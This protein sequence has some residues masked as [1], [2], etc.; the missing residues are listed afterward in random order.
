[1][2]TPDT[3]VIVRLLV[4]DDPV[5][6][7]QSVAL[8]ES[9]QTLFLPTTVILETEWVLRY[10][11]GFT[12]AAIV[13]ALRRLGGLPQI[14]LENG[15]GITQALTWHEAGLDFADALHLAAALRGDRFVTFDKKLINT[16]RTLVELP[17]EQP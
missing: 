15:Y 7:R 13:Q 8:F 9:G 4:G 1:M 17:V 6:S 11:Y 3:N 14:E 12:P 16:A 2:I 5:Q 10:A